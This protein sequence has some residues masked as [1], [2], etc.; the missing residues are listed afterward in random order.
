MD[1]LM[2][3]SVARFSRRI[4]KAKLARKLNLH[5]RTIAAW[6]TGV[7]EPHH[8]N[9]IAWAQELGFE[10]TLTPKESFHERK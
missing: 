10:L 2:E 4:S 3:L 9:L 8:K 5:V 6:E 7:A 1:I